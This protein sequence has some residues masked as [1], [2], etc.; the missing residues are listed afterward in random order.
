[1]IPFDADCI[2]DLIISLGQVNP[3]L[4]KYGTLHFTI[5]AEKRGATWKDYEGVCLVAPSFNK[6]QH[7]SLPDSRSAYMYDAV[8]L[9]INAIHQVGIKRETITDYLSKSEFSRGVTGSISFDVLGN[10]QSQPTLF[11]IENGVKQVIESPQKP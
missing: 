2:K 1:M 8:N 3:D 4:K 11:R 9:V 10:R 7:A 5:G 6:K